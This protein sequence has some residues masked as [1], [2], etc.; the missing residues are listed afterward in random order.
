MFE[1]L[2]NIEQFFF[3]EISTSHKAIESQI[4]V[5]IINKNKMFVFLLTKGNVFETSL[6]FCSED[7]EWKSKPHQDRWQLRGFS[8]F[9][10]LMIF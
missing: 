2:I 9:L 7:S 3:F 4:I 8:E 5:L 1:L 6:I 10:V